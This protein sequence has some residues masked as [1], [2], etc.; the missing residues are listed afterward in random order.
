MVLEWEGDLVLQE[1]EAYQGSISDI[2]LAG[3]RHSQCS[4]RETRGSST[5]MSW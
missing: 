2:A 3:S 1:L 5:A 4:S